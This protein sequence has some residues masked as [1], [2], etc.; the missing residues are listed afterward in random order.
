MKKLFS[1]ARYSSQDYNSIDKPFMIIN[2]EFTQNDLNI[3]CNINIPTQVPKCLHQMYKYIN[4]PNVECYIDQLRIF[5]MNQAIKYN[6]LHPDLFIFAYLYQGMGHILAYA[7]DTKLELVT[8]F[9]DG[10]SNP[11]ER[12]GNKSYRMNYRSPML[13]D[14]YTDIVNANGQ[15]YDYT[16]FNE[17]ISNYNSTSPKDI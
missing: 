16:T 7:V 15:K 14:K 9:Y 13:K 17:F 12:Y 3:A 5:S 6:E 10:G 8:S 1:T 11:F 2:P 4:S